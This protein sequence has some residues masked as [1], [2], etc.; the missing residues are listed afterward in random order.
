[1]DDAVCVNIGPRQRRLRRILGVLG[2]AAGAAWV[3]AMWMLEYPP[4]T[5]LAGFVLFQG[6][7]TG[8][9]QARAKTC[10]RLASRGLRNLDGGPEPIEDAAELAAVRAQASQVLMQSLLAA[11]VVSAATLLLPG[12]N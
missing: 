10:I 1:M 9:L 3:L 5:R 6:G 2:L 12:R 4:Y 8:I 11:A 7:F